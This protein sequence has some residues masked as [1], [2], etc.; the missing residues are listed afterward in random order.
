M[1]QITTQAGKIAAS[2]IAVPLSNMLARIVHIA[3]LAAPLE[4][5][6]IQLAT[7]QETFIFRDGSGLSIK[8]YPQA[9]YAVIA[10]PLSGDT[11][12]IDIAAAIVTVR[13]ES[14]TAVSYGEGGKAV[15]VEAVSAAICYGVEGWAI[16]RGD[17]STA[18]AFGDGSKAEVYG[19]DSMAIV[20]DLGWAVAHRPCGQLM[21]GLGAELRWV[22][23]NAIDGDIVV[24]VGKG[25]I[26]PSTMY[27]LLDGRPAA[28][29]A[30]IGK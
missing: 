27:H 11:V 10:A 25:G 8:R 20:G 16:T 23:P 30:S 9:D 13:G 22:M 21:G 1:N 19:R 5:A 26:A 17:Y 12:T 29:A 24:E 7:G 3:S 4:V 18:T 15:S 6:R 14:M 28:V 2:V